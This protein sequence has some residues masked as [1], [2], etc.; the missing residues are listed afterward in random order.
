MARKVVYDAADAAQVAAAEK[1]AADRQQDLSYIL[2]EPRGRRWLY[3][4]IYSKCHVDRLSHVPNDTHTSAFHEGGR[5][6][7]LSLLEEVRTEQP[8]LFL[9]ML[10]E[11]LDD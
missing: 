1:E 10:K 4:L 5:S 7:G 11:N 9:M 6:I 8:A 3:Y 2:K